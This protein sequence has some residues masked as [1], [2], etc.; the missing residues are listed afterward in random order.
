MENTR[1]IKQA[2]EEYVP[3]KTKNVAELDSVDVNTPL[4]IFSGQKT[5]DKGE[6]EDYEYHYIEV[7]GIKYRFPDSAIEQLQ[8]Q[9]E[10]N[11]EMKRF[12]VN[13]A[14]TGRYDTVYTVVP[15]MGDSPKVESTQQ[16]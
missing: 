9:L 16:V 4:K 5:N 2:A 3:Q 6:E 12:K 11:P 15:I 13:R 7:E 10:T 8:I 14:G 1:S